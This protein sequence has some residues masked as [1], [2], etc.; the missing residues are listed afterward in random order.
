MSGDPVSAALQHERGLL[1]ALLQSSPD[2]IYFK[3]AESRFIRVSKSMLDR[4][5]VCEFSEVI[6]KTDADFYSEDH[7][8]ATRR[9][10]QEIMQ[11]GQPIVGR[12]ERE[13]W[14]D[15]NVTWVTLTKLPL[16]DEHGEVIGTFGISR[17]IT[18]TITAEQALARERD[19]L[20]ALIDN[21]PDLIFVKDTDGRFITVNKSLLPVLNV[22]GVE[23]VVGKTDFDFSPP[24][25]AA[26][27]QEDDLNVLRSGKELINR[28]EGTVHSDGSEGWLLTTKV[29]VRDAN[30]EVVGLVGIGRDI[31]K[32]KRAELELLEAKEQADAANRA[33]SDFLA[34]V[35]HEIRTPLNAIIGMTELLLDTPLNSTQREYM[36][37]VNISGDALLQ[38]ISDVLDFSKIEA[39]KL[40][41]DP[42]VFE[43]RESLGD[44]LKSLGLRAHAKHLELAYRIEE[45]VPHF[46]E[47]D[48]GRL[49]Q[50]I[51][52]LVGNAIKFT[53]QGEVV[54]R[55]TRELI[56]DDEVT[57]R[58]SVSDTG[59][60]IAADKRD[61]I[62]DEFV[63][64][65]TSTT[66]SFGGTGL[67]L[68]IASRL[69]KLMGGRIWLESEGG[70]GSTFF[71]T[72]CFCVADEAFH[73]ERP[74]PAV[75]GN[76]RVL[77]VDDN[78][79]NRRIVEE[80]LLNWGA[81]P[82]T[83]SNA[84]QAIEILRVEREKN[85]PFH[86]LLTDV[87]MPQHDGFMLSE[88][89]RDDDSLADLPII[90]LTSDGRPEAIQRR[91]ELGISASLIKPIKQSEL[92]DAMVR[93]LGVSCAEDQSRAEEL[94]ANAPPI[95]PLRILLAEDNPVN[96]KLAIGILQRQGHSITVAD[97]GRQAVDRLQN[98]SFDVVL[99]DIQMPEMDGLEATRAI[100]ESD[101][102]SVRRVPIVAM[103]AHAMKGDRERCLGAGMD[104]YLS[105]PIRI[106]KLT[107]TLARVC[108]MEQEPTSD[109]PQ[110]SS[111]SAPSSNSNLIN[112]DDALNNVNGDRDLL[113]EVIDA[114]FDECATQLANLRTGLAQSDPIIVRRAAH[115][116]KGS[117]LY[118][119]A[120]GL[121]DAASAIEKL[122]RIGV[123]TGEFEPATAAN[124]M[125]QLEPKLEELNAVLRQWISS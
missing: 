91:D 5:N 33:K 60:G 15:G 97:N 109:A 102:H 92:F 78:A 59:V 17:D 72:A 124:S 79:T 86:L 14:P 46:V 58:F 57:L 7:A 51:V 103:T 53:E 50:V 61:A 111:A 62:F 65:D 64:A 114:Y 89:I 96:Q 16:Q 74:S 19:L 22:K 116:I 26:H 80:M 56:D 39:G 45:E 69:V 48:V 23:D 90:M 41:L 66:R 20:R 29:P 28:E 13:I 11:S 84:Q 52:N 38:Q 117:L 121:A 25:L 99:M 70:R 43:V 24:E 106:Q 95:P 31:T 81:I 123:E 125:A 44:T 32:R 10:E 49:R 115:T 110:A 108:N 34:N 55:A 112:W 27:Y 100:R 71:F 82:T 101:S 30:G 113:K 6:G 120:S 85:T 107:E 9:D 36:Q 47:G 1:H 42:T 119:G 88:W 87:N 3:D 18:P 105:K 63:Q 83:V 67:G 118:L 94:F 77:V 35:S 54:M 93:A 2:S 12:I 122:G 75:V 98:E 104:D 21:M 37:L 76:S 4:F 40:E 73:E 8:A 68:A